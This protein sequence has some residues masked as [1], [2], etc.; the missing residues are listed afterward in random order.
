MQDSDYRF[1]RKSHIRA[2]WLLMW[3]GESP[4]ALL[5]LVAL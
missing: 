4:P 3:F 1:F 5:A 2:E